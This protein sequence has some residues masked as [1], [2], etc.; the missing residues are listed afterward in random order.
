MLAVEERIEAGEFDDHPLDETLILALQWLICGEVTPQ[1]AG[2]RQRQV[3][4]GAHIPPDF[5][6]IPMLMREYVL[7]LQTRLA[8]FPRHELDRLPETFAFAEGRLLAIHPFADFNGRTTR[9]FLSLL[10]RRL[11]LPVVRLVPPPEDTPAYLEALRAADRADWSALENFWR[12]RFE[13]CE[14]PHTPSTNSS[15]ITRREK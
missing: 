5:Y 11:D 9:V 14:H 7:D 15:V 6:R 10:L 8:S 1:L 3:Q 4:V 12:S 13:Q 2:W